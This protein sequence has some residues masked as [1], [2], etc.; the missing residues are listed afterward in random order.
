VYKKKIGK[1]DR[2]EK[3]RATLIVS[4][5]TRHARERERRRNIT[6]RDVV[7]FRIILSLL[8]AALLFFQ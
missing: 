5:R 4:A 8:I 7:N 3:H 2:K 6:R 1:P